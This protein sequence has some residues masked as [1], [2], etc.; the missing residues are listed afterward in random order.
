MAPVRHR[1]RIA[2]D[3]PPP[4][5]LA[6]VAEISELIAEEVIDGSEIAAVP[7]VNEADMRRL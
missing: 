6:S 7:G 4:G 3:D 1:A 2:G 5:I